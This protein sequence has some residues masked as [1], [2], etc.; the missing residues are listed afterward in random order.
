MI[1]RELVTLL[2]F[3]VDDAPLDRVDRGIEDLKDSIG[4][5]TMIGGAAAA[6][7][8]G[9]TESTANNVVQ[10]ERQ[11][12][13]VGINTTKYQELTHAAN[14]FNLDGDDLTDTIVTLAD[15]AQDATDGTQ[16]MIDDFGL[17]GISVDEL[18]GKKP[19]ELLELVAE[20]MAAMEDDGKRA[21][22][23]AR[24]LGDDLNRYMTPL[25]MEGAD[26]IQRLRE[27][28]HELGVVFDEEAIRTAKEYERQSKRTKAVVG[29]LASTIAVD[30][31]PGITS[32]AIAMIT[33]YKANKEVIDSK[34]LA[35]AD[36]L[37][38]VFKTFL[39]ILIVAA[40]AVDTLS[41]AVGGLENAIW[42]A[43]VALSGYL[44]YQSWLAV[45]AIASIVWGW[46]Q[47]FGGWAASIWAAEGGLLAIEAT[48][49]IAIVLVG[50][51]VL[52]VQDLIGWMEGKDSVFGRM[53][54]FENTKENIR[55]VKLAL[56]AI[57]AIIGLIAFI[58]SGGVLAAVAA[59]AAVVGLIIIYW[60]DI[61]AAAISAWQTIKQW[62]SDFWEWLAAKFRA[63]A[64]V[65]K[66]LAKEIWGPLVS[67]W[68]TA[69]KKILAGFRAMVDIIMAWA[70][71]IFG[72]YAKITDGAKS[73]LA[74]VGIGDDD[75]DGSPRSGA[76]LA[77]AY[78]GGGAGSP[79]IDAARRARE[80]QNNKS[81]SV[82]VGEM[83][84]T[85]QGAPDMSPEQLSRATED[86]INAAMEKQ[87][88]HASE[89]YDGGE[90]I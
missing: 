59:V 44:V 11:A 36:G 35:F 85:I 26:G 29:A 89:A 69:K 88:R 56:I 31:M 18:R 46:A 47:A 83:P 12:A 19:D 84:V 1:I 22:A 33:W 43:S 68:E 77:G 76:Q 51:M 65:F 57:L 74:K 13:L 52:A 61:K 37:S 2:G 14:Q 82:T 39:G 10:L 64:N 23:G 8:F 55:K 9:L 30:L 50:L 78:V 49:G 53:F 24:L 4:K 60:D 63:F 16:S 54:G 79:A 42:L 27:E 7:V 70:Q 28:A 62:A 5:L 73:V 66:A 80:V 81:N 86:G 40:K 87:I 72:M 6:T 67:S 21:A 45:S 3:E 90:D 71:K 41:M 34:V 17:I 25:L 58:V 20:K 38:I 48:I 32:T 75:D 15:R